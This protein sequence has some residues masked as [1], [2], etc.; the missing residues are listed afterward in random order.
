MFSN[1]KIWKCEITKVLI[2]ELDTH[3]HTFDINLEAQMGYATNE[4]VGEE[5]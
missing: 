1:V 2:S 3:T 4:K 5:K